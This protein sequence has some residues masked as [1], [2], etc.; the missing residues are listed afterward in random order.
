MSRDRKLYVFPGNIENEILN[1]GCEQVP[2]MRTNEFSLV[3]MNCSNII[4]ELMGCKNGKTIIHTMSGTAALESV[5]LTYCK[6]I[7][8]LA[9]NAG[10]F[11]ARWKEIGDYHSLNMSELVIGKDNDNYY[12]ELEKAINEKNVKVVMMQHHETSTGELLNIRKVGRICKKY[13]I[14]FV[15]DAISSF[16]ADEM[17]MEDMNID[18]VIVST[19]K[20]LNIPP[21]L[22]LVTLSQRAIT[23]IEHSTYYYD[24]ENNLN[25][26]SRGQTPFS[27]ATQLFLQLELRLKQIVADTP[28]VYMDKISSRAMYF[29]SLCAVNGWD[30][31]TVKKSNAISAVNVPIP[32][33]YICDELVKENIYVMPSGDPYLLRVAHTGVQ[34]NIDLEELVERIVTIIG[35]YSEKK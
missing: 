23:S 22:A 5:V 35:D 28:K 1:K 34:T 6:N 14:I 27:P 21:G 2:Y 18:V 24:F 13:N 17:S 15:V 33:K 26:L 30:I 4:T 7:S 20:A 31:N 9:I 32:A 3:Y 19:Q 25:N 12:S 29:R 8:S 10:G 11:G 16:L